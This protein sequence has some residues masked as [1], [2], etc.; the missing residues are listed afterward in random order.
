MKNEAKLQSDILSDLRSFGKY[1]ECFKVESPSDN[2]IPDI[3]FTTKA[4]G[5]FLIETKRKKGV[6]EKL[7]LT[8]IKGLNRCGC[9]SRLIFSWEEWVEFKSLVGLNKRNVILLGDL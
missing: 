9:C 7:Q 8:K 5:P 6:A 3:F 2:G 4:T 1:C